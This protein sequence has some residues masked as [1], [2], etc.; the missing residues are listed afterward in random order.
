MVQAVDGSGCAHP[1][2]AVTNQLPVGLSQK[3]LWFHGFG[4][5]VLN[6][7][8]NATDVNRN[9]RICFVSTCILADLCCTVAVVCLQK[10][11]KLWV[12]TAG[13]MTP[14][15]SHPKHLF[16]YEVSKQ[17][18][19][20]IPGLVVSGDGESWHRHLRQAIARTYNQHE[21]SHPHYLSMEEHFTSRPP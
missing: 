13:R 5:T 18:V 4:L 10:D 1:G 21:T 6:S 8:Y 16:Y 2:A 11:T 17:S 19:C 3:G 9:R 14:F 12:M 20:P 7:S 15:C